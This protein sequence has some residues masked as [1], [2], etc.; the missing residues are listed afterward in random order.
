MTDKYLT[1][2]LQEAQFVATNLEQIANATRN[3]A[4]E[5]LRYAVLRLLETEQNEYNIKQ[6]KF[7]YEEDDDQRQKLL[8]RFD[9][10]EWDALVSMRCLDEGVMWNPLGKLCSCR[11]AGTRCNSSSAAT[12]PAES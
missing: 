3:S 4:H 12:A 8:E 10:G 6:H 9:N 2:V 7:T 11:T 1:A 5:Y